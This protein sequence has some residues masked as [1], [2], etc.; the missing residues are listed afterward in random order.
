MQ[1]TLEVGRVA[2][3]GRRR[4]RLALRATLELL[5]GRRQAGPMGQTASARPLLGPSVDAR[6]QYAVQLIRSGID[7]GLARYI[8]GIRARRPEHELSELRENAR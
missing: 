3:P 4:K 5:R 2:R 6:D 7:G 8:A 1:V